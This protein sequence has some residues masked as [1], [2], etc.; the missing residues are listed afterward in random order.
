M[1]ELQ[2][3]RPHLALPI[4]QQAQGIL[5]L[6]VSLRL[7]HTL[8]WVIWHSTS[9]VTSC[10]RTVPALVPV[11]AFVPC[12]IVPMADIYKQMPEHTKE[13]AHAVQPGH[14]RAT[15][16]TGH[17]ECQTDQTV[18]LATLAACEKLC[19]AVAWLPPWGPCGI[20]LA[21]A[22]LCSMFAPCGF[23]P[24]PAFNAFRSFRSLW[25]TRSCAASPRPCEVE[26]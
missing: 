1:K 7:F 24:F 18:S 14:T 10:H 9:A 2:K 25:P 23:H 11:Q 8:K 21:L 20:S 13:H 6:S 22:R 26:S 4:L 3:E 5:P 19:A 15:G 12:V 17:K 16:R